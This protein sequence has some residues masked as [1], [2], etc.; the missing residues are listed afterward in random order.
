MQLFSWLAIA[1]GAVLFFL[2]HPNPV[3]Q[4]GFF[5]F[6]FFALLPVFLSVRTSSFKTV[7]LK[8]FVYGILS[9][10]AS[11]YWLSSYNPFTLYIALGFYALILALV[12]SLLKI[13]DLALCRFRQGRFFAFAFFAQAFIWCAYEYVKTLGFLG[14]SYGGLGYSQWK[15]LP[16]LQNASWG[17]VWPLSL[18]CAIASA[19]FA[20]VLCSLYSLRK[21]GGLPSDSASFGAAIRKALLANR[22]C[23]LLTLFFL[24]FLFSYGLVALFLGESPSLLPGKKIKVICIQNNADSEKYGLDVYKRDVKALIELSKEA[25]S[26]NPG[27]DLVVWPE[28]AVVPPVEYHYQK[29][30]DYDRVEIINRLLEFLAGRDC[31]FVIGNQRTVEKS[32]FSA[33]DYNAALVFDSSLENVIPPTPLV[34]QKIHLI[35]FAE[36]FPYRKLAPGIYKKLLLD[37]DRLWTPGSEYTVF[38]VRSIK[39]S[40]PIC[41]EDTFGSLCRRFV[42]EGAEAFVN[43]SNDSW[44]MSIPCQKQHLA[45]SVFRCAENRIPCARS[46]ASGV[47]AFIDR[48]G[49]VVSSTAPFEK[50]FLAAELELPPQGFAKSLYTRK[51]D[52]FALAAL[53]AGCAILAPSLLYL[54][55]C[56]LK[57][58][59][60]KNPAENPWLAKD[61]KKR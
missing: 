52:W 51:G 35:P 15:N 49:R 23:L 38:N 48:F 24:L 34:Y 55:L 18:A 36:Y 21:G 30:S 17:G 37:N 11:C 31:A 20:A 33:D 19:S 61:R 43:I 46:T 22:I 1:V 40:V 27:A 60:G 4:N 12:F 28:T 3:F 50:N 41:F 58:R 57:F 2:S 5:L 13:C 7:W 16:L 8:G 14:F 53:F 47:T 9:Y 59:G 29:R 54:F 26:Q 56:M 6:G 32:I 45:M 44:S 25:L 10:G 39:F 42:L